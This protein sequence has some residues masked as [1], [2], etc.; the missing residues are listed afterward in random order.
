VHRGASTGPEC[1]RR[2]AARR[3]DG[4][5]LH[6]ELELER[7][8]ASFPTPDLADGPQVT[9]RHRS[10]TPAGD[11]V[12]SWVGAATR[13][14]G[15]RLRSHDTSVLACVCVRDV[16]GS[17]VVCA[18]VHD[19]ETTGAGRMPR[20]RSFVSSLTLGGSRSPCSVCLPPVM[21]RRSIT[22]WVPA[23]RRSLPVPFAGRRMLEDGSCS[24]RSRLY[25]S[26][27]RATGPRALWKGR[28][29]G[30]P[31]RPM[32]PRTTL[33]AADG[34]SSFP[35]SPCALGSGSGGHSMSAATTSLSERRH[36]VIYSPATGRSGRATPTWVS[37]RTGDSGRSVLDLQERLTSL[38]YWLDPGRHF[39]DSTQQAVW[40]PEAAGLPV[41]V[42]SP[43]DGGRARKR[44]R[45]HRDPRPAT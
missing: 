6:D 20:P 9:P 19:Q 7:T 33:H 18:L 17:E 42:S 34:T 15:T 28:P 14:P 22:P 12:T 45:S 29:S 31:A 24:S 26:P 16:E 1:S 21:P 43:S 38:G 13:Q 25:G 32:T 23:Q 8:L 4:I 44:G 10:A 39:G 41:T 30:N 40:R 27:C 37:D 35:G 5:E 2:R 11:S 36:M 3:R